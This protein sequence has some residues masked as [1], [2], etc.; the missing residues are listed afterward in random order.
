MNKL[1][2]FIP[3]ATALLFVSL[4][5]FAKADL[6]SEMDALG[7]N[8]DL[9]KKAKAIDPNNKVRVVQN[10]QVD[11]NLRLEIGINY[12]LHAAGTDPYLST[13]QWGG[14]MDFHITPHWSLGG[15]YT[16]Y[17][18]TLNSEGRNVFD[19]AERRRANGESI[20]IPSYGYSKNSWLAVGNW[21]PIYGKMNML[22]MGVAQFDIYILGGAGQ[23][24]LD[25]GSAPLFTAGGGVGLWI[26]KHVSTR[27]EARWQGY[28][29]K[30]R[31]GEDSFQSRNM[32][33]TILSATLGFIL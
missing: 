1:K 27:L 16:N 8:K 33:E 10:R 7:A 9:M 4:S 21:Y 24:N 31:D 25:T 12:G 28:N 26:A 30:V 11:R 17:R 13:T 22:D 15:R 14:Q 32:N 19:D 5:A 20:R 29:Q 23:I 18:S 2:L 6:G 3:A